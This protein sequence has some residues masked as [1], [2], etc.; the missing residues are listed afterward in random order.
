MAGQG[1]DGQF[2]L[3]GMVVEGAVGLGPATLTLSVGGGGLPSG[4][5][6]FGVEMSPS[7]STLP[8]SD[9][10]ECLGD[11]WTFD[12]ASWAQ[13][14]AT[15]PSP[16]WAATAATVNGKVVLFGGQRVTSGE[17]PL[18]DTWTWDGTTWTQQAL[19]LPA[20]SEPTARYWATSASP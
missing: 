6:T 13:V 1:G 2:P 4:R 5:V 12:G 3:G 11:T 9:G 18:G 14:S 15:G 17:T 19:G 20:W 8:T 16:R 7:A 10:L